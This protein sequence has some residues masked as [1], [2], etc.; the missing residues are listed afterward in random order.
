VYY[1]TSAS[2]F[3]GGALAN[4]R[5]ALA[6]APSDHSNVV[7]SIEPNN[8]PICTLFGLIMKFST[9]PFLDFAYFLIKKKNLS[10]YVYLKLLK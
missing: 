7:G 10:L 2:G 4:V 5:I 6:K 9:F 1:K 8:S 3:G